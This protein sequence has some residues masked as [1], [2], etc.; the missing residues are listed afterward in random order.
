MQV[1]VAFTGAL[2]QERATAE[3]KLLKDATVI[4]EVVEFPTVV[5]AEAGE[6]VKVKSPTVTLTVVVRLCVP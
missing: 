3:L 2:A 1:T 4:V 5:A 6:A